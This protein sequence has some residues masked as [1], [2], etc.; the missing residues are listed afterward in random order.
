MATN[1]KYMKLTKDLEESY[2]MAL[3]RFLDTEDGGTCN[4]DSPTI[5]LKG[6]RSDA[7][8]RAVEAAGLRCWKWKCGGTEFVISTGC[9][10]GNRRTRVAE[11][12]YR[13]MRGLG[14]NMGMYY[15]MD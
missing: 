10:Q 7:L 9:G 11:F 8:K 15:A 2:A 6:Y 1:E 5:L 14:Y 3:E 12:V 13:R 4:F